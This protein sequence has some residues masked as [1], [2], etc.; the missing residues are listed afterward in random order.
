VEL[1][2]AVHI[3]ETAMQLQLRL[4]KTEKLNSQAYEQASLHTVA[5]QHSFVVSAVLTCFCD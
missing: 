4:R 5:L 2:G 3:E 1:N